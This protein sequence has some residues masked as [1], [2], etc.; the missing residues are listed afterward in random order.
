M[1]TIGM[2]VERRLPRKRKITTITIAAAS[3]RVLATS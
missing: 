3:A 2:K 1:V